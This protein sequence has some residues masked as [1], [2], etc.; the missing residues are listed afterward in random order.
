MPRT[1]RKGKF[2]CRAIELPKSLGPKFV[3]A[4]REIKKNSKHTIHTAGT[5]PTATKAKE[6]RHSNTP[7]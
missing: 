2:D 5:E 3:R 6:E 1:E 4:G 7:S